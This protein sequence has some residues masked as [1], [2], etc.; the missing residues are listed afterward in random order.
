[1]RGKY[2][3]DENR[4]NKLLLFGNY[5]KNNLVTEPKK[6]EPN[7]DYIKPKIKSYKFAK[8]ERF[9]TN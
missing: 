3:I 2:D 7:Y 4:E 8:D 6:I 1:M 5:S 9:K